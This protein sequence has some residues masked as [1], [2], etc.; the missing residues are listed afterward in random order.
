MNVVLTTIRGWWE[1]QRRQG[2]KFNG[3]GCF[4]NVQ[5]HVGRQTRDTR[6]SISAPDKNG[7]GAHSEV[8]GHGL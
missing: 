7:G 4:L 8:V 2:V 3:D 1:M 6:T 5:Y